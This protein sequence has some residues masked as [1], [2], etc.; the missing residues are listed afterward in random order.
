[1]FTQAYHANHHVV[2]IITRTDEVP[3]VSHNIPLVVQSNNNN[4]GVY[5]VGNNSL[6]VPSQKICRWLESGSLCI[7]DHPTDLSH[8][9]G[10]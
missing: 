6:P 4:T 2:S 1:M 9:S 7:R 10:V 3:R 8:Y 5:R